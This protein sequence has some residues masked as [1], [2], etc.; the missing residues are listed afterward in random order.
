[1]VLCGSS[2]SSDRKSGT[3]VPYTSSVSSIRS[4]RLVFTRLAILPIVSLLSAT[5]VG[6]PGLTTKNA[7][8][9]GSSSFLISSSVNWNR[10][11]CG[12]AMLTTFRA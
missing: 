10:F 7:L 1:M 9:L 3:K 8:I 11:S 12:A 2:P 6:L 5:P 4:G